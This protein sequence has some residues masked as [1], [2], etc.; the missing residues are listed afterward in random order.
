[1]EDSTRQ[2]LLGSV[3]AY[4][5]EVASELESGLRRR[6]SRQWRDLE[7]CELLLRVLLPSRAL[8][9]P[10]DVELLQEGAQPGAL[11]E[12]LHPRQRVAWSKVAAERS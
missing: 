6:R 5:D 12:N 2:Q 11:A 10:I 9:R 4:A 3:I 8:P 7:A 1:M